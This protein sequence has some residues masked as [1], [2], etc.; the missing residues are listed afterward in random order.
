VLI[1]NKAF[2]AMLTFRYYRCANT[3]TCAKHLR[4]WL[5]H[6][7]S[8]VG[9]GVSNYSG[10]G[11]VVGTGVGAILFWEWIRELTFY[12]LFFCHSFLHTHR[13]SPIKGAHIRSG[14][15][16]YKVNPNIRYF[17]S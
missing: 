7:R 11:S 8:G 17:G 6:S 4:E 9:V 10:V 3:Y 16:E 13:A 12:G 1:V 2:S 15:N 14:Q 5:F